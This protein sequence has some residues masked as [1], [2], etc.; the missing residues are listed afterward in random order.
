[1][2]IK[3]LGRIELFVRLQKLG[4]QKNGD[5]RLPGIKQQQIYIRDIGGQRFHQPV[6]VV[7]K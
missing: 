6:A 5:H 7:A 3:H 2:N 1:M 4:R